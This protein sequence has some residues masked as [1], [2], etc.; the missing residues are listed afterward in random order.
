MI[1]TVRLTF[2]DD[3]AVFLE[4]AEPLLVADPVSDQ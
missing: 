4:H 1:D 3:P 2:F